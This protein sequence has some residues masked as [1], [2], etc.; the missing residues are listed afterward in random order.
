MILFKMEEEYA[1]VF[2]DVFDAQ[3]LYEG[4]VDPITKKLM[5]T[6]VEKLSKPKPK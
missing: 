6:I 5:E 3:A 2:I 4:K 1:V